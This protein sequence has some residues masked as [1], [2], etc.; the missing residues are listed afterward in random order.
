MVLVR[1]IEEEI[2]HE[3]GQGAGGRERLGKESVFFTS[4]KDEM[5]D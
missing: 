1:V 3:D 2:F 5:N 4:E